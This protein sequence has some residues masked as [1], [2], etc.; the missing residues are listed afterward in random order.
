MI[1]DNKLTSQKHFFK[2]NPL[3]A[4]DN[5]PL[6]IMLCFSLD[7]VACLNYFEEIL[8]IQYVQ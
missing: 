7:N 3:P 1:V 4:H 6:P 2:E 8:I 5:M